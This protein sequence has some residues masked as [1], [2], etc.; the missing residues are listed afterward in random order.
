MQITDPRFNN[1]QPVSLSIARYL[2]NDNL[3][4]RGSLPDGEPWATYTVNMGVALSDDRV[5]LKT[6][7]EGEGA[8][9]VLIAAGVIEAEQLG[10]INNNH[11]SARIYRLTPAARKELGL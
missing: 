1:T 6:W 4:L 9:D 3:V 10:S 2:G 11:V 7:S 8:T 5:A